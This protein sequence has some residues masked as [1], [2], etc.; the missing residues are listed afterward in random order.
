MQLQGSHH[1]DLIQMSF[2]CRLEDL[3][4]SGCHYLLT[5]RNSLG[6]YLTIRIGREKKKRISTSLYYGYVNSKPI[7]LLSFVVHFSIVGNQ[8]HC[9]VC[10][11]SL[12]PSNFIALVLIYIYLCT[13]SQKRTSKKIFDTVLLFLYSEFDIVAFVVHVGK[14]YTSGQQNKQ[15]V[16]VTDGS[17]M[18]GLQSEKFIDTLLAIC[19]CTPLINHDSF[20]PINQNLVGSTVITLFYNSCFNYRSWTVIQF[21]CFKLSSLKNTTYF[22]SIEKLDKTCVFVICRLV[23]VIL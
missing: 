23:S 20:P 12:F 8:S 13:S 11:T 18:K 4:P 16:F 22:A 9:Q 14:A 19:F 10:V 5:Q 1:M 3:L 21:H 2:D 6:R 7:L 17:I 15:W